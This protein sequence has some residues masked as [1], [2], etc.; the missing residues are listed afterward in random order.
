M[1]HA[2]KALEKTK[3]QRK[4]HV[5][6]YNDDVEAQSKE[7]IQLEKELR[8]AWAKGEFK[9]YMT[10]LV[11]LRQGITAGF[12]AGIRWHHPQRGIVN[13]EDF[14][15]ISEETGLRVPL[16]DWLLRNVAKQYHRWREEKLNPVRTVFHL[17]RSQFFRKEIIERCRELV[18]QYGMDPHWMGFSLNEASLLTDVDFVYRTFNELHA[19]G[20]SIGIEGFGSSHTA[21]G[22]LRQLP[23]DFVTIG[24]S[25]VGDA[26]Q[27]P[28]T[29]RYLKS[30]IVLAQSLGY[31]VSARGVRTVEQQKF[32][33]HAG[34]SV[35]SGDLFGE[36]VLA[37]HAENYLHKIWTFGSQWTDNVDYSSLDAPK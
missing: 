5:G 21:L 23:I 8:V 19:M 24:A 3:E 1:Q 31:H 33:S 4:D 17:S 29:R 13:A 36:A 20:F 30:I 16:L 22:L 37:E 2:E 12:D 27:N 26:E 25:M 34:L 15:K 7:Q 14:S 9:A 35:Q 6:F 28:A 10:P 18:E 32:L 11:D